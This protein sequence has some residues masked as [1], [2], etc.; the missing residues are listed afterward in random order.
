ML[1]C[2]ADGATDFDPGDIRACLTYAAD[3]LAASAPPKEFTTLP[4]AAELAEAGNLPPLTTAGGAHQVSGYELLGELGRGG[5]G[6]V[7]QARQLGLNRTVALKMI[8]AGGH[9]GAKE[10]ARFRAEAEAIARLQ[11]PNIVQIYQIGEQDGLPYLC[12]E[13]V[14]GGTLA[15]R[16]DGKPWPAESAA[17]LIETLAR[18]VHMAHQAGVVHRDLKPANVLLTVDGIAKITDFG[19]AKRLEAEGPTR[20][21]E[22]MGT[23]EYMAPE[24]AAGRKDVG[25]AADVWALGAILYE[26]VTG[27]PPFRGATPLDTILQVLEQEPAPVR[28]L[29]RA[30]VRDLETVCWK[31]LQKQPDRRYAS[32]ADLADDLRRALDGEPIRAKPHGVMRRLS[33]RV[34]RIPDT[35]VLG[36][37]VSIGF[38]LLVVLLSRP[39]TLFGGM[40]MLTLRAVSRASAWGTIVGSLVGLLAAGA[41][42]AL[43]P[44]ALPVGGWCTVPLLVGQVT[45]GAARESW[46]GRGAYLAVLALFVGLALAWRDVDGIWAGSV[47]VWASAILGGAARWAVWF[48]GGSYWQAI[49]GAVGGGFLGLI[50]AALGGLVISNLGGSW[51]VNTA[52]GVVLFAIA[53]TGVILGALTGVRRTLRRN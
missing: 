42:Y 22:V 2:L 39:T 7:Y 1:R 41:A 49:Y 51:A 36:G 24:Q 46:L 33:H 27:R 26:L 40:A 48:R 9:A 16:L 12:L 47:G 15:A 29:N 10:R 25:P 20:T 35:S 4:P 31:C 50:L 32:A 11:H 37:L 14:P 28:R 34:K 17:A 13:F 18:A 38:F 43:W 19:L 44:H 30:A 45:A 21:G 52:G 23:P 5:M 3:V 6:V 53:V 8:L